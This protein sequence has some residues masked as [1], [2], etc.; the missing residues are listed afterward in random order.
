MP[1]RIGMVHDEPEFL[2]PAVAALKAAGH[3]VAMF[4]DPMAALR[5]TSNAFL[6][7][8]NPMRLRS[9]LPSCLLRS[10]GSA[11]I[12]PRRRKNLPV[13]PP[14]AALLTSA[15][16]LGLPAAGRDE[17]TIIFSAEPRNAPFEAFCSTAPEAPG[18]KAGTPSVP[19]ALATPGSAGRVKGAKRPQ[20][21][22]SHAQRPERPRAWRRG[23]GAIS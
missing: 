19:T 6:A 15:A 23:R 13:P 1:A 22:G 2:A 4:E 18:Q 7:A 16:P 11:G 3:D 8:S 20:P 21:P 17:G 5:G 12:F 9:R 14:K 10:K